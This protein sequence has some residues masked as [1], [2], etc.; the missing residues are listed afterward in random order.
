MERRELI[1]RVT[2]MFI[3][4]GLPILVLAYQYGLRPLLASTR[5]IDI[6][7]M[8]PES[9][10]FSPDAIR[11]EAGQ[12]F[13]LR[14][15][16]S[17]V[18]HGVA[19]GP[20]L[21][22]DFGP[23]DPGTVKEATL[24]IDQPGRYTFYCN[25]WCSPN[26]WRMRGVI[27]V[28][29]PANPDNLPALQPDPVIQALQDEAIDIDAPRESHSLFADLVPSVQRGAALSQHVTIPPE[30]RNRDWRQ[31]HTPVEALDIL[32]DMNPDM[33]QVSLADVVTYLW[34]EDRLP[35]DQ[36]A[37]TA[38]RYNQNC[39]ACH[40]QAGSGD[41]PAAALAVVEPVAFSD[42]GYMFTMRSDVLYAKIRRGG[43]G[44][45]M[46]NFGTLFTPEETWALVDYLWTLALETDE[47]AQ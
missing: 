19:I 1:A 25:T 36:Y 24:T 7:A 45:D 16:A 39:A 42:P 11:V 21:D 35:G 28:A 44:T 37:E 5:S 6:D 10:G 40:G 3:L 12:P 46:P 32:A 41:G 47:P 15:S 18:T 13:T 33:A 4:V 26:H 20:G 31:R 14:F 38:V 9:G 2:L 27:D 29:D 23:I 43:M 34:S 17:D 22:I 30:L 8:I